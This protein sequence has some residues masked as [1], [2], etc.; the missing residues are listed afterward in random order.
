MNSVENRLGNLEA[1]IDTI[2]G[3]FGGNLEES[4]SIQDEMLRGLRADSRSV[5]TELNNLIETLGARI[6]DSD[7]HIRRLIIKL[8]EVNLLLSTFAE[9]QDTTGKMAQFDVNDPEKLY[10]QS[11][12]DFTSGETELARMG[13]KQYINLYPQTNLADNAL[14]WIGE[15]YLA[16]TKNDSAKLTFEHFIKAFPDSKKIPTTLF[17]LGILYAKKGNIKQAIEYY[18]NVAANYPDTPEAALT[19]ARLEELIEI[20]KVET[21]EAKSKGV[22]TEEVKTKDIETKDVKTK[23]V[24]DTQKKKVKSKRKKKKGKIK[25]DRL[26]PP[27]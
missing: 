11:Y 17:K 1:K 12:L 23:E 26:C 2:F 10:Q 19:E 3:V 27:D 8:D 13:F 4:F 16:E 7:V 24:D 5:S 25:S 9:S 18:K 20:E 22:K 21:K 14:Y 15:T 6:T